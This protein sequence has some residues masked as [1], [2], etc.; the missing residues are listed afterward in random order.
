MPLIQA[1]SICHCKDALWIG[2]SYKVSNFL[3][4]LFSGDT[5]VAS[6]PQ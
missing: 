1:P 5:H 6:A 3:I 4:N 2:N